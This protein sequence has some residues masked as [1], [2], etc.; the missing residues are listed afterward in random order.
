MISR[1]TGA[2][3]AAA[4]LLLNGCGDD[5]DLPV[6]ARIEKVGSGDYQSATA[7]N[8]LAEPFQI[9]ATASDGTGVPREKVI[10]TVLQGQGAILSDTVSVTDGNGVAQAYLTLGPSTGDYIVEAAL[11]RNR[12]AVLT[13]TVHAVAAPSLTGVSP[14]TFTA[15]DEVAIS[16]LNITDS[17]AIFIGGKQ[18]A[19][20]N[21]SV[22]GRGLWAT[23]PACLVPGQVSIVARVG[24]AESDA[25]NGTFVAATEPLDLDP[26]EYLSLDPEVLQ[27]CATFE[28]TGA[29]REYLFAPQSVTSTRGLTLAFQF[30]GNQVTAPVT[31]RDRSPSERPL[32]LRFDDFLRAQEAQLAQIPRE[33]LGA[34]PLLA[35]IEPD[36]K[37]GDRRFFR[38]C[39]DITCSALEDFV[40]VTGVVKYA[41]T[42]AIIYQDVEAPDAG[43][44][45]GDFDELGELFDS[46]LYEVATRA[47]GAESD[48]DRNGRVFI[49][50]TPVVNGLTSKSQCDI[51]F[52][53]G[54]F[55][56]L[57]LDPESAGD[58][59]SNQ[60]EVFYAMVPDP[61]GTVTCNHTLD[62][63]KR[64][65]PVT[66]VHEFQHMINFYQHV[67]VRASNSEQ[68]WLNEA[69]SHMSEELAALHFEA[70]GDTER[71]STFALGQLF[72]AYEYLSATEDHFPLYSEGTGVL[73]ERGAT[74]LLL[75]WLVDQKGEGILRRLTETR[76]VG[77]VNLEAA[78]GEPLSGLLADWFLA[79]YVSNH[80]DL[81]SV[82]ARLRFSTW[83]FRA[84]YANLHAQDE[85]LFPK[86]FP[87]DPPVFSSGDFSVTGLL[88]S[89]SGAY[90]RVVQS[91]GQGGFTVEL[92]DEF[93][94]PLSGPAQPILNLIRIK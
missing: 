1:G 94:D 31:A 85:S 3:V 83:D 71:F 78:A 91:A 9:L 60:A 16:G 87:I 74:W 15:G 65:V 54:F 29:E 41:G 49:L 27:G 75:R 48:I 89:G 59:R 25:I 33:P 67:I 45:Q 73:E 58:G 51:S 86:P 81:S 56:P 11:A 13:F 50:M 76:L 35:P 6:P 66:F 70:L 23:V 12:D 88:G 34:T 84:T 52:I 63:V 72:N 17:T 19:T 43:L 18:A 90:Y 37:V 42:R 8:R 28:S 47:F 92:V 80:P 82:P 14:A 32:A 40:R 24:L 4:I 68:T 39:S 46:D 30:K 55:F 53:T 22:T 77:T 79:N 64:L 5:L 36:I 61:D 21:V 20:S 2:A 7:G 10:W 69:L 93:G 38:V 44:D 26:G 62:R 57:D